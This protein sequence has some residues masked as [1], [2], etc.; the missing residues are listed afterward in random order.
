MKTECPNCENLWNK[1]DH[2]NMV[3]TN[4][5]SQVSMW[6]AYAEKLEKDIQTAPT[7]GKGRGR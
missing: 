7:K 2:Y 1:M 3:I 6:K 4:L 5:L